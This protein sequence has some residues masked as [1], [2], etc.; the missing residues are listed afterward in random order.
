MT[1]EILKSKIEYGDYNTLGK[2]L[3]ISSP[4]AAARFKR[5]DFEAI[6][7]MTL[8]IERKEQLIKDYQT[9]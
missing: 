9:R 7:A 1:L 3:E 4:S 8:L 6:E 5:N 2:M